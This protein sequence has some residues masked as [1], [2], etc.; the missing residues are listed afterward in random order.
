MPKPLLMSQPAGSVAVPTEPKLAP[1]V[2]H[3][4]A[5][6]A[7][8]APAPAERLSEAGEPANIKREFVLT[9]SADETL[10]TLVSVFERATGTTITNSHLLRTLLRAAAEA[11]PEIEKEAAR[12][13]RMKRPS[14][15]R[16]NESERDEFERRLAQALLAALAR[17]EPR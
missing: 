11:L 15:A 17:G 7:S 13:G 1:G 9:P 12:L 3:V 4:H 16:G 5:V 10:R 2:G 14:N 8:P 6:A